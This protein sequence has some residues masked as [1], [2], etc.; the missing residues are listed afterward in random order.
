MS[1]KLYLGVDGGGTGTRAVVAD[2]SGRVLGVGLAGSTSINHHPRGVVL[3]HLKRAVEAASSGAGAT[4]SQIRAAFLGVCGVSTEADKRSFA[5]L[6]LEVF[7]PASPP[8]LKVEN[9]AVA[10]LAGGLSGRPG[11]VLIAGTGSACLGISGDGRTCWVGGW[12]ALADD[13]GSAGWVGVEAI[14]AAVRAEDGRAGST[15]LHEVVF[16]FLGLD[17][18][19]DLINRVH[20]RGLDRAEIARLAPLVVEAAEGGDATARAIFEEAIARLSSLVATVVR[21]LD[22]VN[23]WELVLA[24]G[25]ARS[26][27]PFEPRLVERIALDA[28]VVRV[29]EPDLPPV[30]GAVLEALR[31]DGASLAPEVVEN[32]RMTWSEDR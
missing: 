5:E 13:D 28:S 18:P 1:A 9:D 10:G 7:E 26:G 17:D 25:L 12:G 27:P 11:G 32:L 29:V 19:R 4:P 24:G 8:L 2:R 6:A 30:G 22:V 20:N 14:R 16:G 21:R 31:L 15:L 3:D 23:S